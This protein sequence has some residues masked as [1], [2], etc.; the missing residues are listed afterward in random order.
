MSETDL[1]GIIEKS[2]FTL[3]EVARRTGINKGKLSDISWCK[4]KR[5]PEEQTTLEEVL[6]EPIHFW[7]D[8]PPWEPK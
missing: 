5:T 7:N 2:P 8:E 6:G 4:R 3:C 1:R